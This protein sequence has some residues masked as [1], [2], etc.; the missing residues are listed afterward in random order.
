MEQPTDSTAVLTYDGEM[1]R[2]SKAPSVSANRYTGETREWWM[3]GSREGTRDT[4]FRTGWSDDLPE[5]IA[6]CVQE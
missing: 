6:N 2:L 1:L 4:L 5:A 3:K